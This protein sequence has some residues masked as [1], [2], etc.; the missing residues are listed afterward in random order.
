VLRYGL[1]RF[2]LDHGLVRRRL[3]ALKSLGVEFVYDTRVGD[4]AGVDALFSA[5]FDAV[6]LGTGARIATRL[7][8]PGEEL[9]GVH[10]ATPFLVRANV[11]QNLR[12]SELEEPPVVGDRVLVLGGGNTA[13]D[14]C[15]T[16]LRLGASEVSCFYPGTE[17]EM[18]GDPRE[19]TFAREEGVSL[20]CLAAPLR[21]LGD[22]EG[23]VTGIEFRKV[24]PGSAD[25]P[26]DRAA[27]MESD[28]EFRIQAD[29][30]VLALGYG[31]DPTL[32]RE[33]K[34]LAADP[35]GLVLAD[36]ET[37]RTSRELVWAGGENVL[38]PSQV[39]WAVAQA[40]R[41]AL[42]IHARLSWDS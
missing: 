28:S 42:D 12:P 18:P 5:G 19:R 36:P 9:E 16:A 41:A 33:T 34:A 21:I 29:T 30:V 14:C 3:E 38:G 10:L 7:G 17:G 40:R 26:G 13:L 35:S 15:R 1:P 22:E 31:P 37:G 11:E 8:I 32:P 4:G 39:A 27:E 20:H 23:R 24:T 25:A 6:F 2:R